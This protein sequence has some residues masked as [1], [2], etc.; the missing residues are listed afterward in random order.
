MQAGTSEHETAKTTHVT[1]VRPVINQGDVYWVQLTGPTE[2]EPGIPH[3]HVV[4]QENVLNHSRVDTV[5]TCAV[6]SNTKRANLPGNVLLEAGD[7][8]LPRPSVVEVSKVSTVA[9]TQLGEYIGSLPPQRTD[10]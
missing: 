1:G 10:Q 2:S 5:V 8:N 9:K 4:I 6:T 7:G 3:P